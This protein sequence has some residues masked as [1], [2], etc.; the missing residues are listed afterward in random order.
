V[1]K[2]GRYTSEDIHRRLF[3]R[4]SKPRTVAEMKNG[5]RRYI[6]KRHASR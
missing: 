3:A 5:I 4:P 1:R 6:K 2:A